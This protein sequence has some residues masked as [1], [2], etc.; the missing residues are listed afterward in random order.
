MLA[1]LLLVPGRS[2]AM[3]VIADHVWGERPPAKARENLASYVSRTRR[4][5]R[6]AVGER[7]RIEARGSTYTLE[8][9]PETIDLYRFRALYRQAVAVAGSGDAGHAVRLFKQAEVLWQG[10]AL[11]GLPGAWAMSMREVLTREGASARRER[12]D[13]ELRL[14]RHTEVVGELR[15]L[16]VAQPADE[17]LAA[18]LMT[19]LYRG[20]RRAEALETYRRVRRHLVDTLATEP[21]PRLSELHQRILRGDA[22]L[23]V[24]P[25]Y[26]RGEAVP[27]PDTL[28]SDMP[29]FTGRQREIEAVRAMRA[30][31]GGLV[32]AIQGMPGAGKSALAVH[33]AHELAPRYPDASLRLD[34]RAHDPVQPPLDTPAALFTL[35]RMLGIPASRIP[36][37]SAERSAMWQAELAYRRAVVILDDAS[38]PDQVRPLLGGSPASLVLITS[39]AGFDGT[40]GVRCV[41]LGVLSS[42]EATELA[43]RLCGGH[44]ERAAVREVVRLSGGLPLAITLRA[45]RVGAG[46]SGVAVGRA[47]NG[48]PPESGGPSLYSPPLSGSS[49]SGPSLRGPDRRPATWH[50]AAEV[51]EEL[52]QAFELSYRNLAEDQK[53]AFRRL[54]LS[55]CRD[56]TDEM[57]GALCGTTAAGAGPLIEALARHHLL[58]QTA[59]GRHR[60]HDV[61]RSY[62]HHL[63]RRE[64][65]E[66]DRRRSIARLLQ[67]YQE[68]AESAVRALRLSDGGADGEVRDGGTRAD[69]AGVRRWLADEWS[70]VLQLAQYAAAHEWKALCA[71]LTRVMA[72]YLDTE[73]HWEDAAAGHLTALHA[74][75]E[76]GDLRG[77]AQAARDLGFVRFRTGRHEDA[78]QHTQ[79]AL[80]L[81]RSLDDRRA[82]A[83]CLDQIGVVHWASAHYREALAHC[84]EARAIY[85]SVRDMKGE[86]D[87]LGHSGIVYWHLG[88]YRDSLDLLARALAAYRCIGD[89]RGEAKT[90][91]NMGDV[92]K[93][94]G[95]HRDAVRLYEESSDIFEKIAGRQN[96][97]I[98]HSNRGDVHQ[99]KGRHVAALECYRSAMATF[100]ETGDRRNQA[101]I[102]NGIGTTYLLM[103]CAEESLVHFEKAK[104]L[105]EEIAD[106]YQAVRA[107]VGIGDVHGSARRHVS[108]L[109]TYRQAIVIARTI[110]DLYQEAQIHKRMA[111]AFCY[112]DGPGA[113][114]IN[115]RQA[116]SLLKELGLPEAEDVGIR[117]QALGGVA[118]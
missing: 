48:G 105:A 23:A 77:I 116:Y 24:T 5:L 94:R 52:G 92:H 15:H 54:A 69:V 91:N 26:R 97:A 6:D 100:Q 88:R 39:R 58:Q 83:R 30:R 45:G 59:P 38:G 101:D 118:L 76:L 1:N 64:D 43:T 21:G 2:L 17:T 7:I 99:Y 32:V 84:E 89:L 51:H 80:S 60:F 44:V 50:V 40:D 11:A 20:D 46:S 13:L 28:P 18:Q 96:H 102:L 70:T 12:L 3:D 73:G 33:L 71:R 113:A 85:R 63:A 75:R 27:Q 41:P 67:H 35:L 110:G 111:D 90:L 112:L 81:Y 66:S 61:V 114:R 62:A 56:I 108:A 87:A 65:P 106:S 107:L 78:L 86:A 31:S 55:P 37:S 25:I 82:E 53:Q 103:G 74:C 36:R 29:H 117:L 98:L 42:E 10:E 68:A 115:W 4:R 72:D 16:L 109:D 93:H 22:E 57:A 19:A 79:E 9:D 14:G 47:E 8:I 95:Y 34:L 49:L 104:G